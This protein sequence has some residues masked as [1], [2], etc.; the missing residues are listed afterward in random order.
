[1]YYDQN[2]YPD[3]SQG[4]YDSS[5]YQA[6]RY[7]DQNGYADASNNL[8]VIRAQERL[9]REDFYHGETDGVYGPEMR[10]AISQYQ[11]SHGLRTTGY[12]DKA[13][14]AAMGL[15]RAASY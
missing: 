4:Y 11:S 1:M 10:Q 6:Q 3:Q 9:A 13:T 5:V 8:I 2:A 7:D 15:G 14:V 12:L